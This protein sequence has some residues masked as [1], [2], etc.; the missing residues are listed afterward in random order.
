MADTYLVGGALAG[1]D[2]R[3]ASPKSLWPSEEIVQEAKAAQSGRRITITEDVAEAVRGCDVLATDVWVSMGEPAEVWGDR[4]KLLLPYQVNAETLALTGNP[5]VKFMHCLPAFHNADTAVGK[6]LYEQYGL[7]ALEV[8]EDV[9]ESPA[10]IVFDEAENR[11][12]TIK[13]VIVATLGIDGA[14]RRR[15][16]R[17][18]AAQPRRA[19]HG[20]EP[21]RQ[22]ARRLRALAPSRSTTEL[23]VTHGN[24]PQ[25]GLLALQGSAYTAVATYPL[26]ILGASGRDDRLHDRAGAG[27]PAS[28]RE[29]PQRPLST[30]IE[31]DPEDPAF[32]SPT[33]PIGPLYEDDE[34][35]RLAAERGW[36]FKPD[37]EKLRRVVPLPLPQRIFGIDAV[38]SLLER[39][40]VVIC[41]GG[42]GIPT[43]YTRDPAPAGRRLAGVEAVIDK[44]LASA[45][46]AIDLHADVLVSRRTS[47]PCTPAG[48]PPTS[49]RSAGRGRPRS[50]RRSS[51]RARW[52]RRCRRPAR[53]W[54]GRASRRDRHARRRRRAR[55]RARPARW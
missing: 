38:E 36:T 52:G 2:V 46:L 53:S 7:E 19:A 1:M 34:A 16:R 44:D 15:P 41:A 37:G 12:H 31:V 54:R 4:I 22:R 42:G 27:Q 8:T 39:G 3:I 50:S 35:N 5:N 13:A 24:G 29:A 30:M 17:Q 14:R 47:T 6:E 26:D 18:R 43:A 10:S 55:A 20:R 33:K 11:M 9:F 21:A 45:L 28:V 51:R 32:M 25:V 48:A 23:V 49:A 40:Y